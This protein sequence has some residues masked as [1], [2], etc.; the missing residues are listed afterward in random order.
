MKN[1]FIVLTIFLFLYANLIHAQRISNNEGVKTIEKEIIELTILD[2]NLLAIIDEFVNVHKKCVDFNVNH[3][4]LLN[5]KKAENDANIQVMSF[6][7]SRSYFED[8]T[9]EGWGYFYYKTIL[10]VVRGEY[11]PMIFSVKMRTIKLKMFINV[12]I[13][14]FDPPRMLYYYMDKKFYK[15]YSVPCGG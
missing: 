7:F 6:N 14:I 5:I 11:A 2:T 15:Y 9:L 13:M 8:A 10:F 3:P 4:W 1:F 12:P